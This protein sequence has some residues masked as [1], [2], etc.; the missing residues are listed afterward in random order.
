[1][2]FHISLDGHTDLAARIYRQLRDGILDGRLPPGER[3]PPTRELAVEL[4]VS[5]NTVAVAYE[6]LAAEGFLSGQVGR[7]TFVSADPVARVDRAA[8]AGAGVRPSARWRALPPP[9]GADRSVPEFDFRVGAPDPALF[10]L[11]TWRRLVG[12]ALRPSLLPRSGYADPAGLEAL[13]V[14]IARHIGAA[15]S[16]RASGEDVLITQ[17]AQQALDLAGRVLI[18]PGTRVAVEDP[19]YPPAERLFAALGALVVKVPVDAEGLD[20]TALTRGTRLIYTTPS[21]QF[22]L[23]TPMS[24]ARR[25]ALLAWAERNDAVIVED[26]YDSEYRFSDRPLEPLQ[27]LDHHGRVLYVGSFSK[28]L[29]PLLRLG[30]LVAPA[31]LRPALRHAKQ[32][33]D[34]HGDLVT[35][36][37]MASFIDEGLLS[38][39][40][41]KATREYSARRDRILTFVRDELRDVLEIVPSSAGLH[42][43]APVAPHATVIVD[44]AVTAAARAGV[45]FESLSRYGGTREGLVI[46]YGLVGSE[47]IG[48]GLSRLAECVSAAHMS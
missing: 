17:G 40:V 10:P 13:R 34:W 5:R 2:P 3:L 6:R 43:C 19:G 26:D 21:H 36:S 32:L 47:R 33:T 11:R 28:T 45:T 48:E 18:E 27:S 1:M 15:R 44:E 29:L 35:Q 25:T 42:L 7:G 39:H 22:P 12:Q 37:A 30:F 24:L 46:G 23:G 9:L 16:V 38:R 4:D 14:A 31:S 41:R 8:P 20:V